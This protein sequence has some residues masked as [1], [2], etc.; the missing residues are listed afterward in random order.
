MTRG[1]HRSKLICGFV[2]CALI[3][4]ALVISLGSAGGAASALP[5]LGKA[6]SQY[7]RGYGKVRPRTIFNGGDPTGLVRHIHWRS[8]ESRSPTMEATS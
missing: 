5:R 6:T 1:S 3:A 8:S 4:G 7:Q 2:S